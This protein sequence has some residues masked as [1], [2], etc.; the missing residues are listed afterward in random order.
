[1]T[2]SPATATAPPPGSL[3]IMLGGFAIVLVV[4]ALLWVITAIVG[5]IFRRNGRRKAAAGAHAVSE[6]T[7]SSS[8]YD[9]SVPQRHLAVIAAAVYTCIDDSARIVSI[10]PARSDWS[11]EGRRQ[12]FASHRVR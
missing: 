8:L 6:S 3:E 1:M 12:I 9:G 4:L 11:A 2:T 7:S 10:R 5:G